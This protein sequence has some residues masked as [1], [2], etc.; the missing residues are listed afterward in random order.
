MRTQHRIAEQDQDEATAAPPR[1][2]CWRR[3]RAP[4]AVAAHVCRREARQHGAR[5]HRGA[6]ADR[7]FTGANSTPSVKPA[8]GAPPPVLRNARRVVRNSTS[9]SGS[10][11]SM[12]PIST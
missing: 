10:R 3:R 7:P 2:A 8:N 4:C 6:R 12:A 11:F 9:A 1:P 5:E